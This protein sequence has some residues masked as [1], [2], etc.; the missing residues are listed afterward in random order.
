MSALPSYLLYTSKGF[1]FRIRIPKPLQPIFNKKELKKAIHSTD[2][3]YAVRQAILYAANALTLFDRLQEVQLAKLPFVND[4]A[5]V[6][7]QYGASLPA[8]YPS[9]ILPQVSVLPL[10]RD[11]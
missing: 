5:I 10:V 7:K 2:K 4:T 8:H 11:I 9:G 3:A 1:F 6:I